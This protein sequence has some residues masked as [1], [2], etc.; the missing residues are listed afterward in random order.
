MSVNLRGVGLESGPLGGLLLLGMATAAG[1]QTAPLK[2]D[3]NGNEIVDLTDI[4]LIVAARNTAASGPSDPRDPDNNG[5]I[6]AL[7]VRTCQLRCT[8]PGCS[9]QNVAPKANAGPDQT[10]IVGAAVNLT[11][12]AST[13]IDGPNALT[14]AWT[15]T[16]TPAGS[17]AAADR[18]DNGQSEFRGRPAGDIQGAVGGHDGLANSVADEVVV[19]TTNSAP[20]ANAGPDQTKQVGQTVTL[21]GAASSDP[22]ETR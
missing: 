7:D 9:T 17:T 19:S 15:F 6:N 3:V 13:D 18:C 22:T 8:R 10:V 1:P 2:C 20:T 21:D 12:A 5:V 4:N 11:G 14:Y 16:A